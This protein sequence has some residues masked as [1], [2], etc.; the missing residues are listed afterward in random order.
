M[1]PQQ[2]V[3]NVFVIVPLVFARHLNELELGVRSGIAALAFCA[4]SGAVYTFNDVRD[5][6]VDRVHPT[7]RSRPIA[8]GRLSIRAAL[9]FAILLAV[10]ALFVCS[11][12]SLTLTAIAGAYLV[13]N[14]AYS[15]KLKSFAFLDVAIIATGFMLRVLAGSEAIG[16]ST[17]RWLLSCT[18]L[19]ALLL[20]FGKRAHEL[21]WVE[22]HRVD[23]TRPA[24]A[25]YRLPVLRNLM[26]VLAGVT[27]VT[28]LA[29]TLD[30]H[31][32]SFFGTPWLVLCVPF[33][34][35]GIG[36]FLALS[37][38]RPGESPPTESMLRDP[39]FI[40]SGLAS[41]AIVVAVIYA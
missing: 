33:V 41:C 21:R 26:L 36:R 39:W 19:I 38:W 15:M 10:G 22:R 13:Q 20:G 18:A 8:A 9:V 6:E 12:L 40:A 35:A 3:K 27:C 17:S 11:Q 4:L 28:F 31:T 16:V 14:V 37:L 29:Y 34:A 25:G 30:P 7:K 23:E 2:W 32:V 5:V 24:L 1:R